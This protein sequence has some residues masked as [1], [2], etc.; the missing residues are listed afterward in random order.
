MHPHASKPKPQCL[1]IT[2]VFCLCASPCV[3][4]TIRADL[5]HDLSHGTFHGRCAGTVGCRF[6]SKVARACSHYFYQ[7]R[8]DQ[9]GPGA[10]RQTKLGCGPSEAWQRRAW[11][12]LVATRREHGE[13]RATRRCTPSQGPGLGVVPRLDWRGLHRVRTGKN[14]VNRP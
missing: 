7:M 5:S 14:S 4:T 10:R 13:N 12:F 3:S 6:S 11:P 8:C 1:E 9:K 2:G